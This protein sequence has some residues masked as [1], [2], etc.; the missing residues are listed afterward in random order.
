MASSL[1]PEEKQ[2][3]LAWCKKL[4][5]DILRHQYKGARSP[6]KRELI[7]AQAKKLN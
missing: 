3:G 6:R 7:E 4:K 5:L 1:A 2:R